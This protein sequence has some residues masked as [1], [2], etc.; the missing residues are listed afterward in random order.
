MRPDIPVT[1]LDDA[2]KTYST[3]TPGEVFEAAA[4]ESFNDTQLQM[5]KL[6]NI[7]GIKPNIRFSAQGPVSIADE[8]TITPD[9]L[10][11]FKKDR[12]G[13]FI[14]Q[15]AKL[16]TAQDLVSDYDSASQ[17]N[18]IANHGQS[19]L[20]NGLS[21]YSGDFVGGLVSPTSLIGFG[22]GSIVGRGATSLAVRA[23]D[24]VG[25]KYI[26][27]SGAN[28]TVSL[29][30]N[31]AIHGSF[32]FGAGPAEANEAINAASAYKNGEP[33]DAVQSQLNVVKA[34][35][36][37]ALFDVGGV[38]LGKAFSHVASKTKDFLVNKYNPVS[39]TMDANA[40]VD[41]LG[42]SINDVNVDVGAPAQQGAIDAGE[43]LRA[44]MPNSNIDQA[45]LSRDMATAS[46]KLDSQFEDWKNEVDMPKGV[47]DLANGLLDQI[48]RDPDGDYSADSILSKIK[49]KFPESTLDNE[50]IQSYLPES[51]FAEDDVSQPKMHA[52]AMQGRI[53]EKELP[54]NVQK[55]VLQDKQIEQHLSDAESSAQKFEETQDAVHQD[56]ANRSTAKAE[57]LIAKRVPLK[58]LNDELSDIR[59]DLFNGDNPNPKFRTMKSY[60]RLSDLADVSNRARNMKMELA[61][62]SPDVLEDMYKQ[63][64]F[65]VGQ[66]LIYK[67]A[68][69]GQ[70]LDHVND[71]HDP[72]TDQQFQDYVRNIN[73]SG[74]EDFDAPRIRDVNRTPE[75]YVSQ[76]TDADVK[77][78]SKAARDT[79]DATEI[80]KTDKAIKNQPI[81]RKMV[82]AM[83][84]C[85]FG[86]E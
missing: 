68:I 62:K 3:Y 82:D 39:P 61:L 40:R 70:I 2:S 54:S 76:Y 30:R 81:Y 10:N 53:S 58:S 25:A 46:S 15:D 31:S 38:L 60:Q 86:G 17:D 49:E 33:Y 36:Y 65:K 77:K 28:A 73:S 74:L 22:A 12:P 84:D 78:L 55:R 13:L 59:S 41:S 29:L 26:A 37:G 83:I 48:K 27:G 18:F 80:A 67:K 19:G 20:T 72:V 79:E 8:P 42:Q 66:D 14:P 16:G 69:V 43:Q 47:K 32:A 11:E 7:L 52:A 57:K 45:S 6:G 50:V 56:A 21:Y 4:G 51:P 63:L 1:N 34:M 24:S 9:Q 71:G 85:M 64:H 44:D 35:P 75:D 23:L 5:A